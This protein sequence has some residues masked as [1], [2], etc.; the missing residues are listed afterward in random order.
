MVGNV[1]LVMGH[2]SHIE[3]SAAR[4]IN[5]G[6][7]SVPGVGGTATSSSGSQASGDLQRA[8]R[9]GNCAHPKRL[10]LQRS[11]DGAAQTQ[12]PRLQVLRERLF[13]HLGDAMRF[14]R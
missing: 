4:R 13:L 14:S 10:L 9:R 12:Q 1:S 7:A 5:F 3:S 2:V 11:G 8:Q 6:H